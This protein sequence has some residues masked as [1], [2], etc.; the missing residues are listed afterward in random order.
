MKLRPLPVAL[1]VSGVTFA[2]AYAAGGGCKEPKDAPILS[3]PLANVVVGPGRVQFYSAPNI[4]CPMAGVF[5]VPNDE[6]V[7]YA[8]TDDGW[9]SIMYLNPRSKA[10][11]QGWVRSDRL[12]ATGTVGPSQ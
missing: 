6:V 1:F 5:V 10:D 11:F 7:S 8:E 4:R 3:P 12:K 9:T 2:S